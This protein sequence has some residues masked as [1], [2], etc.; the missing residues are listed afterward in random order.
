MASS[1]SQENVDAPDADNDHLGREAKRARIRR[2]DR[3]ANNRMAEKVCTLR[4]HPG[5]TWEEIFHLDLKYLDWICSC[6]DFSYHQLQAELREWISARVDKAAPHRCNCVTDVCAR[7]SWSRGLN[8]L[9]IMSQPWTCRR[10]SKIP[11][12]P[13]R[14]EAAQY[15]VFVD[16]VA[17][18]LLSFGAFTDNRATSVC[19]PP[20]N[21]DDED[22]SNFLKDKTF[23]NLVKE[24]YSECCKIADT[25]EALPWLWNSSKGHHVAYGR[26]PTKESIPTELLDGK[27]F[28]SVKQSIGDLLGVGGNLDSLRTSG[29]RL[30]PPLGGTFESASNSVTI[31]GD[32]DIVLGNA[33]FDLKCKNADFSK[34]DKLQL[35]MYGVCLQSSNNI[36]RCVCGSLIRGEAWEVEVTR[37]AL[38]GVSAWVAD[39]IVHSP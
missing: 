4:K 9:P 11:R 20:E 12:C 5:K 7:A 29:I 17:R 21:G 8:S 16:F 37:E 6:C 35:F 13:E 39:N 18:H 34:K 24:S 2:D 26:I 14:I 1:T 36:R 30:N 28:A 25:E 38:R 15:G 23:V 27:W 19:M 32:A 22:L 33:I 10:I 3:E 31:G